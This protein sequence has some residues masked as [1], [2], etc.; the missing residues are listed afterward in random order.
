MPIFCLCTSPRAAQVS[1]Q[2]AWFVTPGF[3]GTAGEQG[4][5]RAP[6]LPANSGPSELDAICHPP[7]S[8]D[9][10]LGYVVKFRQ[11]LL[12][13]EAE[14][15]ILVLKHRGARILVEFICD[16]AIKPQ[17]VYLIANLNPA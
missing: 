10:P 6:A 1:Q 4:G 7:T 16:M 8:G 2:D 11:P 15:R 13:D 5:T 3:R 17:C 9:L 14:E 12:A